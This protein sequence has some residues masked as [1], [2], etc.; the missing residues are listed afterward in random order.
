[1]VGVEVVEMGIKTSFCISISSGGQ[2]AAVIVCDLCPC[3]EHC[4]VNTP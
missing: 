3:N 2:R 4:A 1:M